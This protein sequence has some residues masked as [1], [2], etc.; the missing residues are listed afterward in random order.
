MTEFISGGELFQKVKHFTRK[1]V[2]LYVAELATVIGESL[3][4][5]SLYGEI[6]NLLPILL[7][8]FL[9]NAGIIYRD[10]KSENILLDESYHVKLADFGLSKWLKHGQRTFTICG[11]KSS[12]GN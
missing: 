4:Y 8:E 12:M 3:L 7:T 10:L 6:L 9:H 2:Q 11:T 5:W 1:L